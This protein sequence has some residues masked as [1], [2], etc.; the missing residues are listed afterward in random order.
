MLVYGPEA[1]EVLVRLGDDQARSQ[2]YE[3]ICGILDTLESNPGDASV[4]RHRYQ[5]RPVWR[6]PVHGS[7]E[8]WLVLWEKTG[9]T[10]TIHYIGKAF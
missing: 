2:L 8:D 1:Y 5:I 6:V 7:G 9:D 4:R 10:I 3:R